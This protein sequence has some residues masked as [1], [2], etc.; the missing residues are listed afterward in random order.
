MCKTF[1][2]AAV[3]GYT[4]TYVQNINTQFIKSIWYLRKNFKSYKDVVQL[5][6]EKFYPKS[7]ADPDISV[8]RSWVL[9]NS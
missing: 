3:L 1:L 5:E 9:L 7:Q 8:R 2:Q 4:F 6:Y